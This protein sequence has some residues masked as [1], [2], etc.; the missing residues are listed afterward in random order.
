[1][2]VKLSA[3]IKAKLNDRV[4]VFIAKAE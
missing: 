1:G 4:D 2:K 3:L